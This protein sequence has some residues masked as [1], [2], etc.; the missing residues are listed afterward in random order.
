MTQRWMHLTWLFVLTYSSGTY[1]KTA[2][3]SD[4]CQALYNQ[5]H[6]AQALIVCQ[7]GAPNDAAA[8]LVLGKIASLYSSSTPDYIKAHQSFSLA[9]N[10]GNAEAQFLLA[11]SFQNGLGIEQDF[12]SA[13]YWFNQAVANGLPAGQFI[14]TA[15]ARGPEILLAKSGPGVEEYAIAH[16]ITLNHG[17]LSPSESVQWLAQA[18]QK[19]LPQAQYELGL[20]YAQG[21]GL[22]RDDAK[23]VHWLYRAAQSNHQGAQSYL[24]WM[25]A[26]GLGD[27]ANLAQAVKWFIQA[28]QRSLE[29]NSKIEREQLQQKPLA[30]DEQFSKEE[31]KDRFQQGI[32]LINSN[33]VKEVN[34]GLALI[35]Q[36]AN[37]NSNAQFYLGKLNQS[38][39]VIARN[40]TH[41][42]FWYQR[43]ASVGHIEAQYSLGWMYAHGEGVSQDYLKAYQ[44][45]KRASDN[46]HKPSTIAQ[47]FVLSQLSQ[48]QLVKLQLVKEKVALKQ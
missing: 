6:Y 32:T 10:Q 8:Q 14:A 18:A 42:A 33:D 44:W 45:F 30:L 31:L 24:A 35:E 1:G 9:A 41:A 46:G 38:G 20:S 21:Q 7:K 13:L 5:Q 40:P 23:A 3:P 12:T 25:Y 36:A 37:E 47:Q 26:L 4:T 43:A 34:N 29:I 15:Q 48:Q 39:T 16:K 11:L 28:R 19:K 27:K 17:D 22:V 2:T